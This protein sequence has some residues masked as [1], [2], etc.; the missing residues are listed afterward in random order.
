VLFLALHHYKEHETN[1]L[2]QGVVNATFISKI[3]VP[4]ASAQCITVFKKEKGE[5]HRCSESETE[6]LNSSARLEIVSNGAL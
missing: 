5:M 2:I 6:F 4:R 3:I 1:V